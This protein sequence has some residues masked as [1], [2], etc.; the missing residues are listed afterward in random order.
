MK[1]RHYFFCIVVMLQSLFNGMY[2][3]DAY[4]YLIGSSSGLSTGLYKFDTEDKE[5]MELISRL[6][7][8][9]FGGAFA[10][11][12]YYC[13]VS[14]DP[15]GLMPIGLSIIDFT[16]G[17][18]SD[19]ISSRAYGCTDMTYDYSTSTMYG[20]MTSNYGMPTS[21][22]LIKINLSDGN[23]EEVAVLSDKI[24]AIACTYGGEM[25]GIGSQ[26]NLYKINKT[27]GTLQLIGNTGVSIKN[28]QSLEFDHTDGQLYWSGF[29]NNA[30]SFFIKLDKQTAKVESRRT[31]QGNA[32]LCALY[33]PFK[34][35]E[36][37]APAQV[38]DLKAENK[39]SSVTLTWNNPDKTFSGANL[40]ELTAIDIYRNGEKVHTIETPGIGKRAE[41]TDG[42]NSLNGMM[43]YT[44]VACNSVGKSI[45]ASVSIYVGKDSPS[46]IGNLQIT[47]ENNK[48]ILSWIAPTTG[49]HGGNLDETTLEYTIIRMPGQKKYTGITDTHFTDDQIEKANNYYYQVSCYNEIGESEVITSDTL[50][51]GEALNLPYY[52]NFNTEF[53]AAQWSIFNVNGDNKTW[54][55]NGS[56][57]SYTYSM[58]MDADEWIIS[59]PLKFDKSTEYRLKYDILAPS[60]FN[61]VENFAVTMGQ[62]CDPS[63]QN[64]ALE[65]LESFSNTEYETRAIL[66][67][68]DESG[69]YCIGMHVYS[70]KDQFGLK[71]KNI[72]IEPYGETDLAIRSVNGENNLTVG[73]EYTYQ[74]DV[75]NNG[76]A[77]QKDFEIQL[78]DQKQ[79]VLT[80]QTISEELP[81]EVT[82][83][84]E[85]KWTP[86]TITATH[87]SA[88][89]ICKNDINVQNN[90]S[91]PMEISIK[92]TG[93]DWIEI[94]NKENKNSILP[95]GFDGKAYSYSEVIYRRDE[96]NFSSG[97]IKEIAYIYQNN[98]NRVLTG[99]HVRIFMLNTNREEISEGWI[100]EEE[101][102]LVYE[103]DLTFEKGEN[104]LNI[105]LDTP[106]YYTGENLC[107]LNQKV[108]DPSIEKVTFYAQNFPDIPR[109]AVINNDNGI[110]NVNEIQ[111][112]SMINYM[113]LLI[114]T[115]EGG[116]LTGKVTYD[117]KPVEQA[118]VE[119]KDSHVSTFTDQNGIYEFSYLLKGDY[120]IDV[121]PTVI[122][123][124]NASVNITITEGESTRQDITLSAIPTYKLSGKVTGI[125]NTPVGNALLSI[126]GYTRY[127]TETDENGNFE[128]PSVYRSENYR[129]RI[130]AAGYELYTGNVSINNQDVA[131]SDITMNPI[132]CPPSALT[133][134]E[135]DNVMNISW[136]KPLYTTEFKYDNGIQ[137]SGLEIPNITGNT[138]LGSAYH[139]PAVIYSVSWYTIPSLASTNDNINIYILAL[140]E[141]GK[142]TNEILVSEENIQNIDNQWNT[143]QL[144][145]PVKAPYGYIVGTR[146][147]DHAYLATDDGSNFSSGCQ[148]I[149]DYVTKEYYTVESRGFKQNFMLRANAMIYNPEQDIPELPAV[150]YLLYRMKTAD[151]EIP[152]KWILLTEQP[153]E[154]L[155]YADKDWT[156]LEN[157]EYTYAVKAVFIDGKVSQPLYSENLRKATI[158]ISDAEKDLILIYPNP[159]SE[160]I[161]IKGQV[162]EVS[163]FDLSGKE[164]YH[165]KETHKINI[166]HL[167]DGLY[168]LRINTGTNLIIRK[169]EIRK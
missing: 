59:V 51:I 117:G 82:K 48:A 70:L 137:T 56:E 54:L 155:S 74:I 113:Q 127:K 156:N 6:Y 105:V 91:L 146:F 27:D 8:T 110:I 102:V 162:T 143:Y 125:S 39:N 112:S 32:L 85:L 111:V 23:I 130:L 28:Q 14:D 24:A 100:P 21:P 22:T 52:P 71:I 132:I 118:K 154:V 87:I 33:I 115:N 55:F 60:V 73:K 5:K 96:I 47:K 142:P 53:D 138:L 84:I 133:S 157:S 72:L 10:N 68:V 50:L 168:I 151:K 86:E 35:A 69:D 158:G 65:T 104:K 1:K 31:T 7:Y 121:R 152:T 63:G 136:N 128:I 57:F 20:V 45:E 64:I 90:L 103:G 147:S 148:Y 106:Y 108:R 122:G 140:N 80:T 26:A 38:N 46:T 9:P 41:W 107:V 78:I 93:E 75:F 109:T 166:A 167:N 149:F 135:E 12:K 153:T 160:T 2:A 131:L 88:R 124:D 169:I 114:K 116:I 97:L 34:L 43:K 144:P 89:V 61:S 101:M 95:Y 120:K 40:T 139:M 76:K 134:K 37:N 99:K 11:G 30:T 17:N 15:Q 145:T 44:L 163:L 77:A 29:D 126:D 119:I 16:S 165:A 150:T 3:K 62:E 13:Y 42:N 94:G 161:Y 92:L 141:E 58:R 98:S 67:K 4:G 66:V 36:D 25:Y 164:L 81:V 19:A 79:N 123:L 129:L 18:L 49:K 159:A 83:T